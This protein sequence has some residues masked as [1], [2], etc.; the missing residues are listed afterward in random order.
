M[1]SVTVYAHAKI[2]L[3]LGIVG[4]YE[5]G[6]HALAMVMQSIALADTLTL[7]PQ[8]GLSLVCDHPELPTDSR[9]L[10]YRAAQLL[11]EYS[12]SHQGIAIHLQKKIPIGAGLGGGSANAAAVLVGLNHLWQL[13][14]TLPE[15]AQLGSQLGSDVPFCVMGGTMLATGRGEVLE[16]LPPLD[17]HLTL[18]K[19][20]DLSISTAWAYQRHRQLRSQHPWQPTPIQPLLQAIH[21][22][23]S[24][25]AYLHNDLEWPVLSTYP[26]LAE[27]KQTLAG[28]PRCLG[29]LMSGSGSAFFALCP[30]AE[31]ARHLA[32]QL[33]SP[34]LD[35]WATHS[36]DRG[37]TLTL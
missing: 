6:F 21:N 1:Q 7:I 30:D 4:E 22:Q 36:L 14:L 2:N 27:L 29:A 10:A 25:A 18:V 5:Q 12:H 20:R 26:H 8:S 15:L 33:R 28:D 13:G 11:Q 34:S 19:P 9:N 35:T 3:F 32:E 16:P 23:R 24:L 17:L 31:A 37:L